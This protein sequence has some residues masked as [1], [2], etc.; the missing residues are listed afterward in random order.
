M[1]LAQ[2]QCN[3]EQQTHPTGNTPYSTNSEI[4]NV[5]LLLWYYTCLKQLLARARVCVRREGSTFNIRLATDLVAKINDWLNDLLTT[6]NVE[7]DGW[8]LG[9]SYNRGKN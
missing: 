7:L 4:E 1:I 9:T 3:V 8:L 6:Y 2:T 5:L